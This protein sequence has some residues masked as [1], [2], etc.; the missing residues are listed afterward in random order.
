M[1][2]FR[3]PLLTLDD[4]NG[5]TVQL[6]ADLVYHSDLL[7]HDLCVP[8]GFITDYASVPIGLWNLLPKVG[9]SNRA[10]IVHD[11]LYVANGV[12]R[13]EAD[14]VFAEAMAVCGV[15]SWRRRLMYLGV[16]AGGWKAWN[17][18]RTEAV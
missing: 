6:V 7:H 17:R 2:A 12:S 8:T 14:A 15:S 10:A 13:A 3:T 4:G 16:R 5:D 18:Y 11:F 9:K 1:S